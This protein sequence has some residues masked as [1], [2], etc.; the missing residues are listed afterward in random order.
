MGLERAKNA[1]LGLLSVPDYA[2]VA[3]AVV[4]YHSTVR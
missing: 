3:T 1:A 4:L 2:P